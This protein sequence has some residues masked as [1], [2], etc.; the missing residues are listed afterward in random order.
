MKPRRDVRE[1]LPGLFT[2]NRKSRR[3]EQL[4]K[5]FFAKMNPIANLAVVGA[6]IAGLACATRLQGAGLKV[7]LFEKSGGASGR[8]STSRGNG[9]KCDHG[10]QY[11]TA[12]HPDFRAEGARWQRAGVAAPGC[13]CLAVNRCMTRTS[14]RNDL[15]AF[16]S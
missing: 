11:F 7:R 3:K 15:S 6:G 1:P 5:F 9:W 10:A 8:M 13:R 4:N 2:K 16:Q 12:R 14:R